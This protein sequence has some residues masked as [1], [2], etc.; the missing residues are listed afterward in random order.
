MIAAKW[1]HAG[2]LK[3]IRLIVIHCTVSPE[4]GTGAEAVANYFAEGSRRASAHRVCDNNSTVV[5]VRD[6]DTAFGAAG[7]NADGLHLELVGQPT[8]TPDEWLDDYS[9]AEL[10]E[11]GSTVREW[12]VEHSVPLRWLSV[13]EVADGVSRGLCTHADVSAAFP[14]VSTGHWDPGPGFPK[15][16]ALAIWDPAPPVVEEDLVYKLA[17]IKSPDK[18]GALYRVLFAKAKGKDVAVEAYDVP[19]D[20]K[21]VE[22]WR[23]RLEEIP[24]SKPLPANTFIRIMDGPYRNVGV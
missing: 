7:A 24:S 16:Q 6:E 8:Q 22:R 12:S 21:S 9:T 1:F 23:N 14:D 15:D 10:R 13:A 18:P 5:C 3:P 19:S 20:P 11:A 4:S 17:W 2:R